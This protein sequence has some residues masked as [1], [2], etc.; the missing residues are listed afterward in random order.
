MGGTGRPIEC[1]GGQP[2]VPRLAWEREELRI[3]LGVELLL[4]LPCYRHRSRAAR[5]TSERGSTGNSSGY[6][7]PFLQSSRDVAP[8]GYGNFFSL[9]SIFFLF[10]TSSSSYSCI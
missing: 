3:P 5:R 7:S 2:S 8:W 1:R 9:F 6:S 10:L 4:V